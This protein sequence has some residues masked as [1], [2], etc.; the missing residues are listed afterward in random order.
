M[1]HKLLVFYRKNKFT[2]FTIIG[3]IALILAIIHIANNNIKKQIEKEQEE[4]NKTNITASNVTSYPSTSQVTG[5]TVSTKIAKTADKYIKEFLNNCFQGKI[6][7]AY[8]MLTDECKEVMFPNIDA[9]KGIYIASFNVND[10][11]YKIENWVN[12]IYKVQVYENPL[13]TG[14]Y[15]GEAVTDYI[16]LV[17]G[18][19]DNYK[20]NVNS[21]VKRQKVNKIKYYGDNKEKHFC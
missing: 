17:K 11:K 4:A 21:Y 19:K 6:E 1:L 16:T 20:L 10:A 13:K 14:K 3:V 7:D 9:F 8:N 5:Q 2:L 12:D 18:E 15:N